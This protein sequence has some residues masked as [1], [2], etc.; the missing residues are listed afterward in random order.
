MTG[1]M[2]NPSQIYFL[3]LFLAFH[4]QKMESKSFWETE[5][6]ESIKTNYKR[7]VKKKKKI[8]ESHNLRPGTQ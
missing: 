4:A 1:N 8:P 7:N 3:Y 2:I 5:L 6:P